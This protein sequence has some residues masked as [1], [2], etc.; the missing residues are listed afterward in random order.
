MSFIRFKPI[1]CFLFVTSMTLMNLSCQGGYSL[2]E[3]I[4]TGIVSAKA[5]SHDD[6]TYTPVPDS[7]RLRFQRQLRMLR[8]TVVTDGC[9]PSL[10]ARLEDALDKITIRFEMHNTCIHVRP[11][12]FDVDIFISPVHPNEF[13][14]V[15]EQTEFSRNDVSQVVLNQQVDVRKLPGF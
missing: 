8:A 14:L 11:E 7:L 3:G 2:Y 1:L 6:S 15:I 12:F 10:E 9:G 13:Q 4:D 5:Y